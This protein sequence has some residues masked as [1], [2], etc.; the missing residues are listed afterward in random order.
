MEEKEGAEE[1]LNEFID[2]EFRNWGWILKENIKSKGTRG[3]VN[4]TNI[5][6]DIKS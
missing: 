6:K 3:P 2:E 5:I 4:S 1:E